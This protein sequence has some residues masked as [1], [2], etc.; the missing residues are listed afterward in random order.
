MAVEELQRS[1]VRLLGRS[2]GG[3]VLI[4]LGRIGQCLLCS[5]LQTL[6][7]SFA[8]NANNA[9][10]IVCLM[11]GRGGLPACPVS[12][13]GRD[14]ELIVSDNRVA[15]QCDFFVVLAR[16]RQGVIYYFPSG[17][18]LNDSDGSPRGQQCSTCLNNFQLSSASYR[19]N[20][21]DDTLIRENFGESLGR[22]WS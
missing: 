12:R 16:G 9:H 4:K 1:V 18:S 3:F 19:A 22:R 11:P 10:S 21:L 6:W 14:T 5:V 2:A 20:S 17:N 8:Q 15:V 13:I 7:G